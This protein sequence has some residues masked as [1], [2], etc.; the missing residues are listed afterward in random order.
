MVGLQSAE[1]LLEHLHG[2][3]GITPMRTNLSHQKCF[4]ARIL[5]SLSQPVFGFAAV[6]F[7]TAVKEGDPAVKGAMDDGEGGRFIRGCVKMMAAQSQRGYADAGLAE[8]LEWN[9]GS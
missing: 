1:T 3:G 4:V 7:P 2:Q 8:F 9:R 6:V 5:Q